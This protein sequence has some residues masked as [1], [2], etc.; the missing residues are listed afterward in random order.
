LHECIESPTHVHYRQPRTHSLPSPCYDHALV[1]GIFVRNSSLKAEH[2]P[3]FCLPA[4]V[5][6]LW[7]LGT[8]SWVVMEVT[9]PPPTISTWCHSGVVVQLLYAKRERV[10]VREIR[11]R[12]GGLVEH[13]VLLQVRVVLRNF[14]RN[15]ETHCSCTAT[16]ALC[17]Y[18]TQRHRQYHRSTHN[19]IVRY[20]AT[21]PLNTIA[22]VSLES[23][24]KDWL[25][26]YLL[27]IPFPHVSFPLIHLILLFCNS[28]KALFPNRL[29]S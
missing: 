7:G 10:D 16:T 24:Y 20:R 14:S 19:D 23:L 15:S 21:D 2:T 8:I 26:S 29:G 13:S 5:F 28:L 11:C 4:A 25:M 12:N 6:R 17:N 27:I 18:V 9:S 22:H 3:Y 1:K